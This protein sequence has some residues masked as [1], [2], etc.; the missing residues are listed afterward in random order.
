MVQKGYSK[1][2]DKVGYGVYNIFGEILILFLFAEF[3]QCLIK[4]RKKAVF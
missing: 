3:Y 1:V 4:C 2:V